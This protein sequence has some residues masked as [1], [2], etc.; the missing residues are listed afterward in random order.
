[1]KCFLGIENRE[2]DTYT[3]NENTIYIAHLSSVVYRDR[4]INWEE[5]SIWTPLSS[6]PA[7]LAKL[8]DVG[9][10]VSWSTQSDVNHDLHK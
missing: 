7:F 5:I 9:G 8:F 10:S 3:G 6:N 1:M 2:T 4:E